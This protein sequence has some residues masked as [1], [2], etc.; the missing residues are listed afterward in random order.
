MNA[1]KKKK[2]VP[3]VFNKKGKQKGQYNGL[4]CN[5]VCCVWPLAFEWV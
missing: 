5:R 2:I 4:L 1:S 3:L